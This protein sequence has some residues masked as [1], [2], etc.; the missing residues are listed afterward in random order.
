MSNEI[1]KRRSLVGTPY[2]MAPEIIAR[3]SYGAEVCMLEYEINFTVF[4]CIWCPVLPNILI[5]YYCYLCSVFLKNLH[6]ITPALL[7]NPIKLIDRQY[8]FFLINLF[9]LNGGF[10]I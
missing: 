2:W 3:D 9:D 4:S 1:P 6:F 10:K 7:L 5:L 8:I